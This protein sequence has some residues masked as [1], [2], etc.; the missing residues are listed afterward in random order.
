MGA[1]M[2]DKG[3][4]ERKGVVERAIGYLETSFLPGRRFLSPDDFNSQLLSWLPMA[5]AR[6]HRGIGCRSIDRLNEDLAAMLPQML[7][8]RARGAIFRGA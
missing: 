5:N 3:H 4:L 1:V 6:I 8:G 7:V 2:L